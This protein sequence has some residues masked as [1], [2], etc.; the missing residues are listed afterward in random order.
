MLNLVGLDQ[1]FGA[2][3][4]AACDRIQS[5]VKGYFGRLAGC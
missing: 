4:R 1:A 3:E 5:F 2:A